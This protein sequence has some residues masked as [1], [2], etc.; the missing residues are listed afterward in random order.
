MRARSLLGEK[1][2]E[3]RPQ[4]ADAA[5]LKDGDSLTQVEG[6]TEIDQLI[7]QLG[8]LVE[9]VNSEA[10]SDTL[11]LVQ[12]SLE[13][14]PARLSRMLDDIETILDNSAKAS[15]DLPA[16]SSETELLV[17]DL[18]VLSGDAQITLTKMRDASSR[19]GPLMD[20]ADALIGKLETAAEPIPETSKE[21]ELLVS[22]LREA[23][24]EG[25][26]V[27]QTLDSSSELLSTVLENLSEID[28]VELRRLLREEGILVRIRESEVRSE[29]R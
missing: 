15:E 10:L 2:V 25:R 27:I 19:I 13:D 9:T 1:F 24:Q 26:T 14:D 21:V 16:I 28:K 18:R 7:N 5:I 6:Q 8:P 22:E 12:G 29:S 17:A 11:A 4:S 23:V 20:R 3:I